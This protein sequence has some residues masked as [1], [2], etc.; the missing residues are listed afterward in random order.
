MGF[1]SI[2]HSKDLLIISYSH[3]TFPK[4]FGKLYSQKM[5]WRN[6][7][8]S[9]GKM[10]TYGRVVDSVPGQHSKLGNEEL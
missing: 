3:F 9:I 4:A 5:S 6:E 2:I 10:C 7:E 8:I 1:F